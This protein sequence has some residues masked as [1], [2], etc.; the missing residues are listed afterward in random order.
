MTLHPLKRRA[1]LCVAFALAPLAACKGEPPAPEPEVQV[2][3]GWVSSR[4]FPEIRSLQS[5]HVLAAFRAYAVGTEGAI[6]RYDRGTWVKEPLP[7]DVD[8]APD[9]ESVSG[10]RDD[11]SGD[12]LVMAVGEGGT[13]LLRD[14][15]GWRRLESGTDVRLFGVWVRNFTDAFLVGDDGTIFRWDGAQVLSMEQESM[16]QREVMS[17]GGT[18]FEAYPIPEPLKSVAG[19]GGDNVLAVGPGGAVY[20][21]DGATWERESA[22]TGRPLS[23]VF[24]E[25]GVWATATDGVLLRRHGPG[26]WDT[27]S[28]RLPVPLALQGAWASGGRD[29]F[30]VGLAGTIFHYD[31][32]EWTPAGL[33]EDAHLRS[34]HGVVIEEATDTTDVV[35]VVFAVGA[36]G[37]IARG[38]EAVPGDDRPD[39]GRGD[40][41]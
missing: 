22:G 15:S 9:L 35:R 27:S 18:V 13:V 24:A 11:E 17:D 1:A 19:T 12:E 8:G 39:E 30:A 20:R 33:E 37:R 4:P 16:Q 28:Y 41:P 6:L 31:G 36:G 38:P 40:S 32:D 2:A 14:A 5:V 10:V 23:H 7:D 34:V 21:F 25:R 3:P 26:D 29:V